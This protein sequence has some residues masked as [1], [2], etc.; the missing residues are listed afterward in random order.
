MSCPVQQS[1][2]DSISSQLIRLVN[3]LFPSCCRV[4]GCPKP[5]SDFCRVLTPPLPCLVI[6]RWAG[7]LL[8]K[9]VVASDECQSGGTFN[10]FEL[11]LLILLS[12]TPCAVQRLATELSEEA[13]EMMSEGNGGSGE[14]QDLVGA[15]S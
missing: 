13:G 6:A 10:P 2:A 11:P 15:W 7:I 8:A 4:Q 5:V 14:A 1:A 12:F 9:L 3:T